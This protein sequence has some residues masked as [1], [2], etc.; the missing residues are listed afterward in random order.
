MTEYWY[1]ERYKFDGPRLIWGFWDG[2]E[3]TKDLDRIVRFDNEAV[4]EKKKEELIKLD[5]KYPE[6]GYSLEHVI[7]LGFTE[8]N[9]GVE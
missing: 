2:K 5:C 8:S 7:C 3:F 1:I 4:A 6:Y 9:C